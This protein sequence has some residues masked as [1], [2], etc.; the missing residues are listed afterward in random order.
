[1]AVTYVWPVSLPQNVRS[2]YSED[3]GVLVARTPVDRGPA[4]QR[5][6]GARPDVLG[7]SFIMSTAQV[8]T[9][10][11]FV[12]DTL[13]GVARFGFPHPRTGTQVEARI[14]PSD[15][16]L[17]LVSYYTPGYWTVSM[18]LEILP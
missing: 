5:R 14:V 15:G 18:K 4:K 10:S 11:T 6:L 7:V 16:G 1:M 17:Y 9:L 8:A 3:S 13:R 12:K 2:D